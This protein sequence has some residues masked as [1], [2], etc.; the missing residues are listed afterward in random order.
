MVRNA[1]GTFVTERNL[2]QRIGERNG[3]ETISYLQNVSA[4]CRLPA[5]GL[6]SMTKALPKSDPKEIPLY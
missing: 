4:F 6:S 2:K 1:T 3:D 5:F